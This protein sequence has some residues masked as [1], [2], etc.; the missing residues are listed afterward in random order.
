ME[1]NSSGS[2]S[3]YAAA[4][5]DI[6]VADQAVQ[7]I[8]DAVCSTYNDSVLSEH[9]SFGGLYSLIQTKSMSEPVLVT[10]TDGVGTKVMLAVEVGK[11]AGI[12]QDIVNHC[13]N[14]ILVQGAQPLFFLDYIASGQ[15]DPFLISEIVSGMAQA[16][17]QSGCA[18]IGGEMAEMP[19]VYRTDQLDIVG[20]IVGLVDR[21]NLLPKM[22]IHPGDVLL[23]LAS[24]GPHT[25]G[26]S[27]IRRIF[28]NIPMDQVNSEL[29]Q[30]WGEAL[31]APHRSYLPLLQSEICNPSSKIKALAHITGGGLIDNI[32]RILPAGMGA[33]IKKDSWPVL[34]IFRFIQSFGEIQDREMY[35]VFNMGIGMVV[36]L[37]PND[38]EEIRTKITEETWVIG[39]VIQKEGVTID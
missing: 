35:R 26:Y 16:C 27:L 8:R 30:S 18:L 28:E 3:T 22:N 25:N 20:T 14:D 1:S 33:R 2:S 13:I 32:P 7:L 24:S 29:G 19:G 34:P 11:L 5:V 38:I 21:A 17:R 31:L 39:E 37:A 12:G 4:G 9:G 10:S 36:I 23:G 6:K 15:L